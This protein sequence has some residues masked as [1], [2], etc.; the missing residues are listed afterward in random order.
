MKTEDLPTGPV[1]GG[2]SVVERTS[3]SDLEIDLQL[4][5]VCDAFESAWQTGKRPQ[6]ADFLT[7]TRLPASTLFVELVQIEMEYRRRTGE[8]VTLEEYAARYPKFSEALSNLAPSLETVS[9][10][11]GREPP[12]KTLGRFELVAPLGEGTF[13][14]VWKARDTKLRRWV[15]IKRFRDIPL[16]PDRDLFAREARAVQK[17]D[18]PNVVRLLELSQGATTDYIVFEYLEGRTLKK[19]LEERN[20]SPL[21]PDRAARIA[22]QLAQGLQHIHDRGLIHR[23]LKPA[24]VMITAA[25][26]AKILDFGL[27]R[28]TD[29]TSTIGGNEGF[30]GTIP[31]MSPEQLQRG[32]GVTSQTDIYALG[33]ILYEMLAGRRPFDGP[34]QDLV[35]QIPEGNPPRFE[36]PAALQTIVS[37]A[38]EVDPLDRH[39]VAAELAEDLQ[40]YIDG[41]SLGRRTVSLRRFRKTVLSRRS[42]LIGSAGLIA[43]AGASFAIFSPARNAGNGKKWVTI[44]TEP[45]GAHVAFIPLDAK[46]GG[47]RPSDLVS[48]GNAESVRTQLHPGDYLVVAHFSDGSNRFHEVYRH[49]PADPAVMKGPFAFQRWHTGTDGSVILEDVIIPPSDV[50]TGMARVAGSSD[51]LVAAN[52]NAGS[53]S[54]TCRIPDFFVD[55]AEFTVGDFKKVCEKRF[56]AGEPYPYNAYVR[57]GAADAHPIR[58]SFGEAVAR[59]E[60]AGKRLVNELEFEW[61]ATRFGTGPFT[62]ENMLTPAEGPA[63][64]GGEFTEAEFDALP[65]G[66][67]IV[68]GLCSGLAEWVDSEM[69]IQPRLWHFDG[70]P[71]LD[72]TDLRAIRGGT[73]RIVDQT[74][75]LNWSDYAGSR[76]IAQSQHSVRPGLGFR[77]AR[78]VR[79]RLTPADFI[80]AQHEEKMSRTS[81]VE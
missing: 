45:P 2:P 42:L 34:P 16:S 4:N 49:V 70:L 77:C 64:V 60:D 39:R 63:L 37:R 55:V 69:L 50:T 59:A 40:R 33:T 21:D 3:L 14:V 56:G 38:I 51:F 35:T 30:L 10:P 13:G 18:H 31:Y 5:S 29:T 41:I 62:W 73:K 17:L 12:V 78:S 68:R 46:T 79:P 28:H 36:A 71:H 58:V 22:L 65:S 81:Q 75:P 61:M 9:M 11:A 80:L 66:N 52:D 44:K 48:A 53:G 24:N 15:A 76:R 54:L 67:L 47:P 27:A 43:S 19:I 25:G 57:G 74:P 72:V 8:R 32:R 6:L 1:E 20:R 26:D 23:D 7:D